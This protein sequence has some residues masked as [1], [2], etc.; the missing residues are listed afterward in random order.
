MAI[1]QF[2]A[3]TTDETVQLIEAPAVVS[4]LIAGADENIDKQEKGWATRLVHYRTFTSDPKLHEYYE[5][6]NAS[7]EERLGQFVDE[8]EAKTTEAN[9]IA[10]LEAL[11]PVLAKI[12]AGYADLLK[13]SWRSMAKKIA[14][15]SGGFIGFGSVDSNESRLLGLSMLD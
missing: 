11:K 6:V 8:W 9:M 7:F 1:K 12:D 13:D 14:E 2:S 15:A 10:K 3:L 4:V 5:E